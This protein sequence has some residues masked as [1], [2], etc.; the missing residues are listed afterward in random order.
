MGYAEQRCLEQTLELERANLLNRAV[1][2]ITDQH[3]VITNLNRRE[4]TMPNIPYV[5]RREGWAEQRCIE[6]RLES[7]QT[8][9]MERETRE[10]LVALE[11]EEYRRCLVLSNMVNNNSAM[12][13]KNDYEQVIE[14]SLEE[15][16]RSRREEEREEQSIKHAIEE[17]ISTQITT[18]DMD[19]LEAME[20][21]HDLKRAIE[22]S[23]NMTI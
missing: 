2:S 6:Q 7:E 23:K 3:D 16:L 11:D 20:E 15:N 8:N 21:E 9:R 12:L 18:S 22:E 13:N 1:Q 19:Y 17:S 10:Y 14:A 5:P 4:T